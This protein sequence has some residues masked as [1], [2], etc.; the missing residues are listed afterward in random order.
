M[1][2]SCFALS[3]AYVVIMLNYADEHLKCEVTSCMIMIITG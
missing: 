1:P 3:T 2:D